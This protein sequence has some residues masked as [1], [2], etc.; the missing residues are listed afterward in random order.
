MSRRLF[1]LLSFIFALLQGTVLPVVFIEG[2]IVVFFLI[3]R[4]SSLGLPLLASGLVFDL[5]QNQTL[6]VTSL[7]FLSALALTLFF[8]E[9]VALNH[10]FV[11]SVFVTALNA[12]RGKLLFG[13]VEIFPLILI[14]VF[15]YLV[16]NFIWRPDIAGKIRI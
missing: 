3:T 9:R 1:I 5:L 7:I 15:S 16:F 13:H 14:F 4:T 11:L 2:L 10:S 8:K 6:G 12:V